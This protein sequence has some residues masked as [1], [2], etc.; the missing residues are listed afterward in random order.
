MNRLVL[1]DNDLVH[2]RWIYTVKKVFAEDGSYSI[3]ARISCSACNR[4]IPEG[5]E[6]ALCPKCGARMD[7]AWNQK[8]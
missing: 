3:I 7:A 8:S 4:E 6:R 5:T 2:A 1:E